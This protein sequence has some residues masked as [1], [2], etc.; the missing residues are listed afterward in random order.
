MNNMQALLQLAS[1]SFDSKIWVPEVRFLAEIWLGGTDTRFEVTDGTGGW[2]RFISHITLGKA[3]L[4]RLV[5]CHGW[6]AVRQIRAINAL[7]RA[8]DHPGTLYV[9]DPSS[10]FLHLLQKTPAFMSG[11]TQHEIHYRTYLLFA[12]L[13]AEEMEAAC[14]TGATATAIATL[15]ADLRQRRQ[16]RF[17]GSCAARR[18]CPTG[19]FAPCQ[20]AH[21][22]FIRIR[23]ATIQPSGGTDACRI[24]RV[25]A[26]GRGRHHVRH[27]WRG[28]CRPFVARRKQAAA[29]MAPS[30]SD[31]AQSCLAGTCHQ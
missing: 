5:D 27:H 15:P 6:E 3:D 22:G 30:S 12:P 26:S 10:R 21:A 31:V 28:E 18:Q 20:T 8:H 2:H 16:D 14:R 24:Y 11:S 4:L 7:K 9:Q 13:A 19:P 29:G 1:A 23:C 17:W 25:P